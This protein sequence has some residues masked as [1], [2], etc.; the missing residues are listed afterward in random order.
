MGP[1][2]FTCS[3][4][5]LR[6]RSQNIKFRSYSPRFE[7]SA[8]P[9][10]RE[11]RE[12]RI[13]IVTDG[14]LKHQV[15]LRQRRLKAPAGG[16]AEAMVYELSADV[17]VRRLP[18]GRLE[19]AGHIRQYAGVDAKGHL[20]FAPRREEAPVIHLGGPFQMGLLTRQTLPAGGRPGDLIAVVGTPGLGP[21]TFAS[22]AREGLLS[23]H[24]HPVAE[25]EPPGKE[26]AKVALTR[27]C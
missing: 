3:S 8:D 23:D 24:V 5:I 19:L 27:R 6:E 21:G 26:R 10:I 12:V 20:R 7:R 2:T 25:I 18:R 17:E 1:W 13:G 9:L 15:R 16:K 4:P 14:F 22:V 11:E